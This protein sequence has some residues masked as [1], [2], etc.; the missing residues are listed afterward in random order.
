[1]EADAMSTALFVLGPER[2]TA[3]LKKLRN[4]HAI[5]IPDRQPLKLLVTPG[6]MKYFTPLNEFNAFVEEIK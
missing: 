5:F 2:G 4:C 6:F 1:V 3:V